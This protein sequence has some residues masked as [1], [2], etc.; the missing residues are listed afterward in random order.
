MKTAG[1]LLGG[2]VV[3]AAAVWLLLWPAPPETRPATPQ[4]SG[5]PSAATLPPRSGRP[6]E[7]HGEVRREETVDDD[8]GLPAD[9]DEAARR[10]DDPRY[11]EAVKRH[12][13]WPPADARSWAVLDAPCLSALSAIGLYDEWRRILADPGGTRRAVAAALDDQACRV[14]R[15]E[16]RPD[17]HGACAADAMV[18]LA[19]LQ[20]KCLEKAH[21]DWQVVH[22]EGMARDHRISDTQQQYH[23]AVVKHNRSLA[24]HLWEAHMCRADMA[25]LAWIEALPEP[26]GDL[27]DAGREHFS[28]LIE[29]GQGGT[30]LVS[31]VAPRLT[32]DAELYALARRLGAEVPDWVQDDVL[33][34]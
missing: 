26:P 6:E 23:R 20:R 27:A 8:L 1:G 16:S 30:T 12:C 18:R 32:Q 19:E 17:L 29:D 22:D 25:A 11:W 9:I 4:V 14:P 15:G 28:E 3:L 10:W 24:L 34:W 31:L 5:V 13:P 21:M 7:R 33:P 2:T